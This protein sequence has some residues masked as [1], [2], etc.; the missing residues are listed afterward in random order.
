[1]RRKMKLFVVNF[2]RILELLCLQVLQKKVLGAFPWYV[3]PKTKLLA[4]KFRRI[5]K[6]LCLQVLRRSCGCNSTIFVLKNEAVCCEVQ[7]HFGSFRLESFG[8]KFLGGILRFMSSKTK[9]FAAK[10]RRILEFSLCA[11]SRFVRPKIKLFSMMFW[12]ILEFSAS[13]ISRE[14]FGQIFTIDVSKN[15]AVCCEVQTHFASFCLQDW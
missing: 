9:L 12:R 11:L 1:M 13:N 5:L 14:S 8:K 15:E 10:F 4:V 2:R 7:T 6:V 3:R